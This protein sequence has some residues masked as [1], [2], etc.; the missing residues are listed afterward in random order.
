MSR[1]IRPPKAAEP[2]F[3]CAMKS[4]CQRP[5]D[6]TIP[7][8]PRAVPRQVTALPKSGSQVTLFTRSG[9]CVL[10]EAPQG[11]VAAGTALMLE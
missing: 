8:S 1:R 11:F 9:M 2:A 5:I 10:A 7:E 6:S 4:L 3:S